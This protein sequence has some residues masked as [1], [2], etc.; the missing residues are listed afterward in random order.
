MPTHNP[1][2]LAFQPL[3]TIKNFEFYPILDPVNP[4]IDDYLGCRESLQIIFKFRP[5]ENHI[6]MLNKFNINNSITP[7]TLTPNF[8]N[9]Q[10]TGLAG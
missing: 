8:N 2:N 7:S 5:N 1:S 4:D 6:L 3:K 10:N 9:R